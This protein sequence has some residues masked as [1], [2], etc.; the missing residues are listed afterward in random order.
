LRLKPESRRD[1]AG[2]KSG[3][4]EFASLF[5]EQKWTMT[6][7]GPGRYSHILLP[8]PHANKEEGFNLKRCLELEDLE[9]LDRS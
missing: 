3:I 2:S 8:G 5:I 1:V 6:A 7:C 4:T 9:C